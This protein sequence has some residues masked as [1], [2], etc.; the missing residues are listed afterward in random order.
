[1]KSDLTRLLLKVQLNWRDWIRDSRLL[2]W[3]LFAFLGGGVGM[4]N[5]TYISDVLSPFSSF[6]F[7]STPYIELIF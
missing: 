5:L 4:I 7:D 3:T 1:M 2:Y 6:V